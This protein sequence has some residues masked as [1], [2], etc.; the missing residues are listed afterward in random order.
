VVD[1]VGET[2]AIVAGIAAA[3]TAIVT[4]FALAGW[5]IGVPAIAA[6]CLIGTILWRT[7]NSAVKPAVEPPADHGAGLVQTLV[8]YRCLIDPTDPTRW[9]CRIRMNVRA[10][11]AG[12]SRFA[13]YRARGPGGAPTTVRVESQGHRLQEP[14]PGAS[15]DL[16]WIDLGIPLDEDGKEDVTLAFE[17][18]EHPGARTASITYRIAGPTER[19][20]LRVFLPSQSEP[21]RYAGFEQPPSGRRRQLRPVYVQRTQHLELV[22]EKPKRDWTYMLEWSR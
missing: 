16:R 12:A 13:F 19:L 11:H 5:L 14:S 3:I 20:Q 18:R 7:S 8:V 17:T 2:A 15:P 9:L 1:V 6:A 21:R 10:V 22:I 4:A